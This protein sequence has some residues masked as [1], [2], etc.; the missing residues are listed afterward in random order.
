MFL[1]FIY[2]SFHH[3]LQCGLSTCYKSS[4]I[5]VDAEDMLLYRC[6]LVFSLVGFAHSRYNMHYFQS[7]TVL[8]SRYST[9]IL[10]LWLFVNLPKANKHFFRQS[11]PIMLHFQQVTAGLRVCVLLS[12]EFGNSE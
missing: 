1:L 7:L 5:D 12:I 10:L 11:I 4:L 9:F 3:R 2:R 8:C 6:C